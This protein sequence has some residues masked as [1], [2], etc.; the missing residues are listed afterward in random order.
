MTDQTLQP[1][2][3]QSKLDRRDF[4]Q[5]LTM[6]LMLFTVAPH[7]RAASD[8]DK[9]TAER[10]AALLEAPETPP[11]LRGLIQQAC[12]SIDT[13]AAEETGPD[14]FDFKFG[15][16]TTITP[17]Q[18]RR[19]LPAR[20]RKVADFQPAYFEYIELAAPKEQGGES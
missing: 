6:L 3:E 13:E 5:T 8:P 16:P 14:T 7:A 10:L 20:L 4:A 19:H 1:T 17:A 2:S 9:V 11:V 12:M 18:I 15:F